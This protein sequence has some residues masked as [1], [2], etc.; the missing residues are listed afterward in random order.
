MPELIQLPKLL[1]CF[2]WDVLFSHANLLSTS[3]YCM[4]FRMQNSHLVE[5]YQDILYNHLKCLMS[6]K[7]TYGVRSPG[8]L[9]QH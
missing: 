1:L 6:L 4:L 2:N 5:R 9:A 8:L 7:T 3:T